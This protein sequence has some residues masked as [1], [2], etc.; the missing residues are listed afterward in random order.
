[1]ITHVC[2]T[3][4]LLACGA[5][6][7]TPA[8]APADLVDTSAGLPPLVQHSRITS[9]PGPAPSSSGLPWANGQPLMHGF[10]GVSTFEKVELDNGRIDGD[11][12]D[13]DELPL[14][15]G[16]AQWRFGGRNLDLGLEGLLSFSGRANAAAFVVGGGG[17]AV[18]VDVDLMI[19]ELYGGPFAS[20]FLGD[21]L[22]L[23]G[24]AGPLMQWANY[25]QSGNGLADDGSGFGYGWYARTG[26][27]FVLPSRVMLGLGARWSDSSVDLGS[28]L[29]D[30]EIDGLQVLFTVSR[31][32]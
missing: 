4:L 17:A 14:I 16:G 30:L 12:G 10:L 28:G 21:K 1:M 26:L 27:E 6:V 11:E 25:D 23:Y 19:F 22:R 15:G 18:A 2:R 31:G 32:L 20:V 24:A 3:S 29:G 13:L 9:S 7:S 5:C 8:P